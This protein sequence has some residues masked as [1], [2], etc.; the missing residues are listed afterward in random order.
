ML[1]LKPS[2]VPPRH[3][4]FRFEA[5]WLTAPDIDQVVR[6]CWSSGFSMEVITSQCAEGLQDWN[7]QTFGKIFFRKKR[8]YARLFGVQKA[9]YIRD[10]ENLRRLEKKLIDEY[11]DTLLQEQLLWFQKERLDAATLQDRNTRFFHLST[12]HKRRS[13]KVIALKDDS[14]TWINDPQQL[15]LM[16]VEYYKSLFSS[17]GHTLNCTTF[18]ASFHRETILRNLTCSLTPSNLRR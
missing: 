9:L 4:P 5:A 7:R 16:A 14:G 6:Q 2:S 15:Q 8:L 18:I 13:S 10:N 11:N 1:S 3:K 12:I 17:E